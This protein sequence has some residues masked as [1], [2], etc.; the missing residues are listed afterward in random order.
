MLSN[1]E[2]IKTSGV[3]SFIE[4]QKIRIDILN[5]LLTNYDDGRSKSFFCQSCALL[6]IDKLQ[7]IQNEAKKATVNDVELKEKCKSARKLVTETAE[8]LG[9]DLKLGKNAKQ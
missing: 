6:P 4:K 5:D 1:L 8:S 7:Y 2:E 3:E 9:I